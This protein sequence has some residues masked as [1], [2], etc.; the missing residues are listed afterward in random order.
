MHD[1]KG[2]SYAILFGRMPDGSGF[3]ANTP[4]DTRLLQDMVDH[5]AIGLCGRVTNDKG[6]NLFVPG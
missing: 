1:R 5:D 2:P 3:I 6:R 4:D